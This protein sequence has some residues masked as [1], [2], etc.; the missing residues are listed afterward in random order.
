VDPARELLRELVGGGI[1][2]ASDPERLQL[3]SL[4][5]EELAVAVEQEHCAVREV[6]G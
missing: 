3:G 6:L 4:H 2:L 5:Q 1:G